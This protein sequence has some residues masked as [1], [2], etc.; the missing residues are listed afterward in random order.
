MRP[1]K[2][3]AWT[4]SVMEYFDIMNV[5]AAYLGSGD[6]WD[7]GVTRFILMQ[8]TGVLDC[9]GK[10]IYEGDICCVQVYNTSLMMIFLRKAL[11]V[12]KKSTFLWEC[13]R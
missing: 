11:I 4:G 5:P 7:D 6:L 3:R 8:F 2:F 9:N 12:F 1:I 13:T 10:E